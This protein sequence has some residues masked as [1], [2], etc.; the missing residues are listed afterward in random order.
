[1]Q[2]HAP[3]I[4]HDNQSSSHGSP[5][6]HPGAPTDRH[7]PNPDLPSDENNGL[8]FDSFDHAKAERAKVFVRKLK[9]IAVD[10]VEEVDQ[11][12]G[13]YVLAVERALRR[14]D[15]LPPPECRND[16]K[17]DD[18]GNTIK[19]DEHEV[20]EWKKWQ[21]KGQEDFRVHLTA[22]ELRAG[23]D[24]DE[25]QFRAYEV[26]N[27]IIEIH[28]KGY[29]ST[30][31][32]QSIQQKADEPLKC[33]ARIEEAIRVIT[34]YARVRVKIFDGDNIPEFC[35]SPAAYAKVT[36]AAHWNNSNRPQRA[37]NLADGKKK[38]VENERSTKK[39][40]NKKSG[41]GAAR[42]GNGIEQEL[43]SAVSD[44]NR[45][46]G[47]SPVDADGEGED[48]DADGEIDDDPITEAIINNTLPA[49]NNGGFGENRFGD[50]PGHPPMRRFPHVDNT[51]SAYF[52]ENSA[53]TGHSRQFYQ[54]TTRGLTTQAFAMQTASAAML[55]AS[56]PWNPMTT[57]AV[58]PS[59]HNMYSPRLLPA[60][61]RHLDNNFGYTPTAYMHSSAGFSNPQAP[62]SDVGE[63]HITKRRK[64]GN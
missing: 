61:V 28:R 44:E 32:N 39:R 25:I 57:G 33:S 53:T 58:H 34:G 6:Q 11:H 45:A 54:A 13:K 40:K 51:H 9:G 15:F 26:V 29:Q 35:I 14:K 49:S 50:V 30:K 60:P 23:S 31:K 38:K 22:L 12:R 18:D 7:L 47:S 3:E 48:E 42:T 43:T 27:G 52:S 4:A 17:K 21:K 5:A 16:T 55:P 24:W 10:D 62:Q 2:T 46:N 56:D 63:A 64:L 8:K 37:G 20:A 1:M 36:I 59:Q 41:V 19:L